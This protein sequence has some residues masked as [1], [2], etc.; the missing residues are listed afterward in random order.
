V[1]KQSKDYYLNALNDES[2][3]AILVF[4]DDE[5]VGTG[6]ISYFRVMPTFCNNTGQK[7]Y[8]MNMYTRPEYRKRGIASKTLEVLV[9]DALKRG[10][11]AISL[12]ATDMGRPVYEKYGFVKMK[13]EME[14]K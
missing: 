12:E 14:L 7:A 9:E 2:H 5:F 6:G 8:I 3:T 4:D 10:I 13:D 11:R 1:E